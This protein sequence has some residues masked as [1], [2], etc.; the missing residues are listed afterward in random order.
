MLSIFLLQIPKLTQ[1][2]VVTSNPSVEKE[3]KA[4]AFHEHLL[5]C[6]TT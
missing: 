5:S 1:I 3:A 2:R 4:Q 6:S